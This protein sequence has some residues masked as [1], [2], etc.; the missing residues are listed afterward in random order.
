MAIGR[1]GPSRM[2]SSGVKRD[3]PWMC[4]PVAA[5]KV[6]GLRRPFA[7]LRP[8]R[9]L[10]A[11]RADIPQAA[12][13]EVG[14]AHHQVAG[15]GGGRDGSGGIRLC[16]AILDRPGGFESGRVRRPDGGICL[17]LNVATELGRQL[18]FAGRKHR[19]SW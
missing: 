17:A 12:G 18:A 11:D 7:V 9:R 6:P 2:T 3:R 16:P 19:G 15:S 8:A 5:E 4:S 14:T 13:Q 10:E 1:S